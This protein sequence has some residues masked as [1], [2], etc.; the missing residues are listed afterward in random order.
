[1]ETVLPGWR[2]AGFSGNISN[3]DWTP[4]DPVDPDDEWDADTRGMIVH[5][6]EEAMARLGEPAENF[7]K[8]D[9]LDPNESGGVHSSNKTSHR[10]GSNGSRDLYITY[11]AK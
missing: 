9:I 7:D 3:P 11:L 5:D 1:M 10:T 2:A 4:G 6:I 8:S